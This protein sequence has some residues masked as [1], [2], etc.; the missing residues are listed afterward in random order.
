MDIKQYV[1]NQ[2]I[3]DFNDFDITKEVLLEMEELYQNRTN[4]PYK[5]IQSL[6]KIEIK[7]GKLQANVESDML[8]RKKEIK[9]LY[10]RVLKNNQVPDTTLYIITSDGYAY[11]HQH[12]P[13]L[14]LAKPL[15]KKGILIPDNTFYSHEIDNKKCDWDKTKSII[16]KKCMGKSKI[17]SMYFR[18]ANTGNKKHNIR[19]SF[20]NITKTLP[21]F[22][23]EISDKRIPIYTF[24]KYK[25][26]LNL[27]G[28]QPWSFRF[29]YL[30]LMK[31]LVIDVQLLEKYDN[32]FNKRWI[33]F[34]DSFLEENEDYIAIEVK[35]DD[36]KSIDYGAILLKIAKIYDYYQK[37]PKKYNK[38]VNSGFAK[39][40]KIDNSVVD[41]TIKTLITEYN[42]K[43][44]KL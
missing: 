29:K 23:I 41:F 16:T 44:E 17:S 34:Y 10:E 3:K 4:S 20:K 38:I 19:A 40:S 11:Y 32:E 27:P 25:Y 43:V 30:F 12:L 28:V 33:N 36:K 15:N 1:L 13:F 2:I 24:C 35:S 26:L 9:S 39:I 31:S 21:E 42:R 22:K 14:C 18:G 8:G 37:N 6:L 5:Y 7:N